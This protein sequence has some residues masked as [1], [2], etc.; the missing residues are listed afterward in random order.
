MNKFQE[1]EKTK[2]NFAL[3]NYDGI[4]IITFI[5]NIKLFYIVAKIICLNLLSLLSL[6]A[7][8]S[9]MHHY[10]LSLSV[11]ITA[12]KHAYFDSIL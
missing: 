10:K 2:T 5:V 12:V 6:P 1:R 11:V 7:I 9:S 4:I 8:H 3:I